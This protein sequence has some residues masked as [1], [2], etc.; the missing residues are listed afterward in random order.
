[1]YI[2]RSNAPRVITLEDGTVLSLADLPSGDTTRWV[3]SRKS[4]VVNAVLGGL[5]TQA[6]ALERY[7]L[8]A[9]ELGRWIRAQQTHGKNALKSTHIGDYRAARPAAE[10]GKGT[11]G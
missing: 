9:E 11:A 7:D 8:S 2:R 1:M 5:L 3:A 10:N 6:E 4:L